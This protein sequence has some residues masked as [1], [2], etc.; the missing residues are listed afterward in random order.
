MQTKHLLIF[1]KNVLQLG[2]RPVVGVLV[3]LPK[4]ARRTSVWARP[5][6]SANMCVVDRTIEETFMRHEI[7]QAGPDGWGAGILDLLNNYEVRH[8]RDMLKIEIR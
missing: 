6:I 5:F 3:K 7:S 1:L 8:V 4:I 2:N